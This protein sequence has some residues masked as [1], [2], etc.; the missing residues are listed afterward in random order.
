MYTYHLFLNSK[1]DLTY[2]TKVCNL[3]QRLYVSF[4]MHINTQPFRLVYKPAK[5]CMAGYHVMLI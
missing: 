3:S 1:I 5:L 2:L 4:S